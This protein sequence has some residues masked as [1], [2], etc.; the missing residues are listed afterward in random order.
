MKTISVIA[1]ALTAFALVGQVHAHRATGLL[2]ASLVDV[3]PSQV[4]VEVT[5]VPGIDIAPKIIALLDRNGDGLFSDAESTAWSA[6]FLAGQRVTVDGRSLPLK[7]TGIHA[8]PLMEMIGGHAEIV[9]S[10][11]ADIGN[12]AQGPHSIVCANRYEP[13]PC[14]FQING[15]VPKVPG[16]RIINHRRDERQQ[17]LALDSE[18]SIP[19]GPAAQKIDS[20][21]LT[22][23]NHFDK[24]LPGGVGLGVFGGVAVAVLGCWLRSGSS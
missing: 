23:Q 9:V 13:I 2:Q 11:T 22:P 19:T 8:S 17:E 7:L 3:Q 5:L 15:L 14:A 20:L 6:H 1:A 18:F 4:A 21:G 24:A 16:V 10:F 12:L